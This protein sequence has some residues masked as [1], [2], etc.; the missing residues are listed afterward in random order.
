MKK[1]KTV[2]FLLFI[3]ATLF[4][5][6]AKAQEFKHEVGGA[7]GTSFYL[8]DANK[9]KFYQH[10][11]IAAGVLY[12]YNINFHWAI[13]AN[14]LAGTVSG[15]TADADN[16]FPFAQQAAFKRTFIDLGGQIEFNF[17]PFCD[18]FSYRD[19]KPYT[20][21]IFTGA[22]TTFAT[23]NNL[24]FN[25][26]IPIGIGFKY[27]IKERLNIGFEFSMRKLFGDDFDVTE[28]NADWDL[29]APYGIESSFLKNRD[30]YSLT[31][32]FL[33]WDFGL[34]NDPCCD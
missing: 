1:S 18:K 15:N 13:K 10:P 32:I 31:M 34:R 3:T 7:L 24:F 17:L 6:N 26:N 9:T 22:G 16:V 19:A 27:K 2:F 12:R 21:Y 8:G 11:G 30:W 28:K 14:L 29:N 20:P 5:N 23:G 25:A 4:V 33:T